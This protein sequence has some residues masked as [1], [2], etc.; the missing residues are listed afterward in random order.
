MPD[1]EL[2]ALLE[3]KSGPDLLAVLG[4]QLLGEGLGAGVHD[5]DEYRRF[6]QRWF[7]DHVDAIAKAVCGTQIVR[8]LGGDF[9]GDVVDL[10]AVTL[11]AVGNNHMLAI[12]VAAIVMRRGVAMFCAPYQ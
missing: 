2:I 8:E 7:D 10:A 12:T 4:A 11:P 6:G 1:T 3:R 9:S 5:D